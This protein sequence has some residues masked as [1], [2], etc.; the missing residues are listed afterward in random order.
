MK[1]PNVV[2]AVAALGLACLLAACGGGGGNNNK[3][4]GN[5]E[6]G[7]GNKGSQQVK[8]LNPL[9]V[10]HNAI[11]GHSLQINMGQQNNSGEAGN[12]GVTDVKGG[13][14]VTINISSEPKGASQPAHIHRGT[15]A[16]LD[17]VPWK[18]LTAVVN[19]KSFTHIA[20]LTVADLKK[21]KYAIN[22]HKSANDL[23]TYVSCG[24]LAL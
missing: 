22:V 8:Q 14:N 19:G 15:C 13:A 4:A 21:G 23:K 9:H 7:G 2:S 24:D 1:H 6:Y 17:P 11:A 5:N 16:K 3:N 18:A 10:A 12:A 20:G